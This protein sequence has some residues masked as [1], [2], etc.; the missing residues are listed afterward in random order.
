MTLF[1]M[2]PIVCASIKYGSRFGVLLGF[3][4][5]LF[6]LLMGFG[7][8]IA[9]GAMN[10][11]LSVLLDYLL[12]YGAIGLAGV[13]LNSLSKKTKNLRMKVL[14]CVLSVFSLRFSAHTLSGVLVWNSLLAV[15]NNWSRIFVA[16]ALYNLSYLIPEMLLTMLGTRV[17]VFY[18]DVFGGESEQKL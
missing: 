9:L 1:S 10:F 16:S 5:G 12:S 18:N 6:K 13:F 17:I 2:V 4:Y 3:C 7:K 8:F 11:W 15:E 14:F